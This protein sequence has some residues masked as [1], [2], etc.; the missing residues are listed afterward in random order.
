[1]ESSDQEHE[2]REEL[3]FKNKA[4]FKNHIATLLQTLLDTPDEN[5]NYAVISYGVS[6]PDASRVDSHTIVGGPGDYLFEAV[7]LIVSESAK[8]D[9][10][11]L[12]KVLRTV[13]D[14]SLAEM[15]TQGNA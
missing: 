2:E 7:N 14:S 11:F 3:S 1:M 15:E 4:Q 12:L 6:E 9:P 13:K 8:A 5:L 10:R